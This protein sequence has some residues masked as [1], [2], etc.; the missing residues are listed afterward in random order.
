M[1]RSLHPV[2]RT[3]VRGAAPRLVLSV[4]AAAVANAW[5]QGAPTDSEQTVVVTAQKRE[6]SAQ[7]VPVSLTAISGKSLESA[8]IASAA[9]LDQVAAGLTIGAIGPGYLSITI[10]GISDLG[11]GLLGGP[12]TGFYIDEVPL[13]AFTGAIPQVAFWDAERVEVL[14]GPQG[15][16]FGE[17]SMGGTVRLISAKPDA[18][19]VSG[20]GMLGW[21]KVASGGDGVTARAVVNV[22]LIKNQ[23]ALRVSAS[24][25]DLP[26]WIDVPDLQAKDVNKGKQ[27]DARVAMRWTPSKALTVDLSYTRQTLDAK[28]SA[29]TSV[30]IYRPQDIVP[31]AQPVAFLSKRTSQYDVL[32]LTTNYDLGPASLVAALSS[33][34]RESSLRQDYTP[35]VPLFFGVGGTAETG[36]DPLTVKSTTAEVR[37]VSNGEQALNW[38]VGAYAKNDKRQQANSGL[39]ISLPAFG[40]PLDEALNTTD[41]SNKATALFADIEYRLTSDLA[42]QAGLRQY[43][44]TNHTKVNFLTTSA[45]F[46]GNTAGVGQDS[47]GSA[48]AT[49]PKLGISWKPSAT[50]L[51]FAK[52]SSGFRDGD[53]NFQ[54][55]NEPLIPASYNPEKIRAYELGLKSQPLSW[56]TVNA[57]VY[58]ND[59]TD[60][61]L[62]FSTPDGLWSYIQNAGKAKSTGA[63]IEFTAR[64]TAALRL[65]LNLAAVNSKIDED[66]VNIVN[67]PA[68]GTI[69]RTIA[70]KGNRIPSSPKFQASV[71]AAYEFPLFNSLGGVVTANYSHR[72]ETY[73]DPANTESLKNRSYNNLYLKAGVNGDVWG[74]SVYVANAT[75]ST[76]TQTKNLAPAGGIVFNNFVQPRTVGVELSAS[77]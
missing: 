26:G 3:L 19:A 14:R 77:F 17:G 11:G 35:F 25:Q 18:R 62:R 30:G 49:S 34:K 15:T 31:A 4:L 40:L 12:A 68:G 65:G 56:L 44:A 10:R 58:R 75:N 16:L 32:N 66:V 23:L 22:P 43:R 7:S 46:A 63:E 6:Q 53:S 47:G 42:L 72:G 51:L 8:G 39:K 48:K 45:I 24:H 2:A 50:M 73:S 37:L 76:S 13:S 28:D 38:T 67:N 36:V 33:Y 20:R 54:A 21:S 59:W 70:T 52:A 57:S 64:P 69:S 27:Q 5:A 41:A 71:S 60:L 74:A 61:Q 9:G 1:T 29:A 55:P